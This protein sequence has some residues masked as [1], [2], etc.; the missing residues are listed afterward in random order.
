MFCSSRAALA[1]LKDLKA[2]C[3]KNTAALG[4]AL[5]PMTALVTSGLSRKSFSTAGSSQRDLNR[6]QSLESSSR[7]FQHL[8]I[9]FVHSKV[10][11]LSGDWIKRVLTVQDLMENILTAK[12]RMLSSQLLGRTALLDP[13]R[14][15]T[16]VPTISELFIKKISA[17]GASAKILLIWSLDE[18]I[19][20]EVCLSVYAALYLEDQLVRCS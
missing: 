18:D 8:D 6:S 17:F 16:D 12:S 19:F 13:D 7:F 15:V 2:R 14:D 5:G 3:W 1:S 9:G 20:L 11:H 4:K 10:S